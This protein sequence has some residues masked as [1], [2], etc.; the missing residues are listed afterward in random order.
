M[1]SDF[2]YYLLT[3]IRGKQTLGEEYCS[4][5]PVKANPKQKLKEAFP[6]LSRRIILCL[7]NVLG[8][9]TVQ[10]ILRKFEQ[11]FTEY[12]ISLNNKLTEKTEQLDA[13]VS[14]SEVLKVQLLN[15][16]PDILFGS[17]TKDFGQMHLALFFIW[18]KY[19]EVAKR[20]T[21]IIYKYELGQEGQ[22]GISYLKPGRIIMLTIVIQLSIFLFKLIKTI[23]T[24]HKMYRRIQA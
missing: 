10:K 13:N 18:G 20:L 3:T 2:L 17:L 24:S 7:I 23:R 5:I 11:P 4:I 19:E 9:Y 6:S 8:P 16:I 14:F 12:I 1:T 15:L 21:K 22:H